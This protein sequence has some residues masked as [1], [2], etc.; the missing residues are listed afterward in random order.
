MWAATVEVKAP[1]FF[2]EGRLRRAGGACRYALVLAVWAALAAIRPRLAWSIFC[3]RRADS[4]L[5]R[6]PARL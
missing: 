2:G 6:I 1:A 3:E 5:R 4:P